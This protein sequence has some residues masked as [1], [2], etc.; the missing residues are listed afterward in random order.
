[1]KTPG[2]QKN[3]YKVN[4]AIDD[5][6]RNTGFDRGHLNPSFYHCD[7][8]RTATFTLTNAVP[9][10]ACFN[11]QI[12]FAMESKSKQIMDE[13]CSFGGAKRFFVTGTIPY[14]RLIPNREHDLEG[15]TTRDYN[16]VSVP[17][18]MWTAACCDSSAATN[19]ADRSKGFSF[20]YLG[21]NKADGSVKA[22]SVRQ[23]ESG[24]SSIP[25]VGRSVRVFAGN[26]NCNE[27]SGN[28]KTALEKIQAVV[29][30]D[31]VN[32]QDKLSMTD[33]SQLPPKKRRLDSQ[34]I[35]SVNSLGKKVLFDI[36]LGVELRSNSQAVNTFRDQL[37]SAS[38]LTVILTGFNNIKTSQIKNIEFDEK[39]RT[40]SKSYKNKVAIP[41]RDNPKIDSGY[42]KN[43]ALNDPKKLFKN[44]HSGRQV[45][46]GTPDVMNKKR[47][48]HKEQ[49]V[50][51]KELMHIPS[52]KSL[53]KKRI[54]GS[55]RFSKKQDEADQDD[56]LINVDSF[57]IATKLS[58]TGNMTVGGD[59]CRSGHS[60]DYHDYKYKWC[61]TDSSDNYD[62][63]CVDDCKSDN[64]QT[65]TPTCSAGNFNSACSMRSSVI[66]VNG[67]RC[68]HNHECGFH[69]QSYYWCYTDF[70]DNWEYCCQPWH[71]C[72]YHG[73]SYK[74]CYASK[75]RTSNWYWRR[76]YY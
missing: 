42:K 70:Y 25:P 59:Y 53:N 38:D 2:T 29:V 52:F 28:S 73:E 51:K 67:G 47:K 31:A 60:C 41:T 3:E 58:S 64:L 69:T 57:M 24:I 40:S 19:Q 56:P 30:K 61:Y 71:R 44:I 35:Q 10:D 34:E 68:R 17:S 14:R 27:K 63:C 12:W 20:G 13:L 32:S 11:Q 18:H 75:A 37:K 65:T 5:D 74:W 23:L 15:D 76:C 55:T 7:D 46:F 9:Q 33:L 43:H 8:A 66:T 62:Y 54:K 22:S 21:E 50:P 39:S 6:Y 72:N 48:I 36:T 1:M 4:Q 45:I 26:D 16:R 49:S